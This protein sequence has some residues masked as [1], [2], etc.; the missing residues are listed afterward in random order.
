V[1]VLDTRSTL[2]RA[3]H[4]TVRAT[5]AFLELPQPVRVYIYMCVCMCV[6]VTCS[7]PARAS[8][9]TVRATKAFLELPQPVSVYICVCMF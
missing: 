3:S 5:K 8:H 6:L 7:N 2:A 1:C 9:C 4:C